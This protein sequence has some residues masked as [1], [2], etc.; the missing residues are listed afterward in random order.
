MQ[1]QLKWQKNPNEGKMIQS[2]NSFITKADTAYDFIKLGTNMA[3]LK[4]CQQE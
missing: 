2:K 3:N 4:V 1:L